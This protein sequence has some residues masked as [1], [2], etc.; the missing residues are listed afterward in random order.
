MS[1]TMKIDWRVSPWFDFVLEDLGLNGNEIKKTYDSD[2]DA[3]EVPNPVAELFAKCASDRFNKSAG[4]HSDSAWNEPLSAAVTVKKYNVGG[5]LL[6]K[7]EVTSRMLSLFNQ[8]RPFCISN[9]AELIEKSIRCL[10]FSL[11]G[12]LCE[13]VLARMKS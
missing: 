3:A 11:F 13:P 7:G 2:T 6:G 4:N 5:E 1:N 8:V 9:E 12:E 10:D